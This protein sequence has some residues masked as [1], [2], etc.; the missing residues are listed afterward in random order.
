MNTRYT[1]LTMWSTTG[2]PICREQSP[3]RSTIA[4][5][6]VTLPFVCQLAEQGWKNACTS[7]TA[8][9]KGLNIAEGK[10]IYKEII[11]AFEWDAIP[12]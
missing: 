5:T 2:W 12:A 1:L 6:N 9:G 7:N 4:L 8:L 3:V 10:V 11:E